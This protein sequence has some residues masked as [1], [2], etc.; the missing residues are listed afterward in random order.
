LVINL[1]LKSAENE[2]VDRWWCACQ[3]LSKI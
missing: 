3:H 1:D 2:G